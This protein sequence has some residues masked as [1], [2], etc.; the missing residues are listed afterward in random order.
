MARRRTLAGAVVLSALALPAPAAAHRPYLGFTE[1]KREIVWHLRNTV[2]Y[3]YRSFS[4]VFYCGRIGW[5][6]ARAVRNR[7]T[8]DVYYRD[9][10]GDPWCGNAKVYKAHRY[11]GHPR[12]TSWSYVPG[13]CGE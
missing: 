5:R 11:Y 12:F 2:D 10:D 9:S 8:C 13:F 3:G 1:A 7:V 4:A 6:S